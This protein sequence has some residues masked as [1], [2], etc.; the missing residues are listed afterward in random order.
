LD[1]TSAA[2][3]G[4]LRQSWPGRAVKLIGAGARSVLDDFFPL[5]RMKDLWKVMRKQLFPP[6]NDD[7]AG[8][9]EHQK[10]LHHDNREK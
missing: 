2:G 6:E 4:G 3:G 9:V 7:F 8:T 5:S 1:W 10:T